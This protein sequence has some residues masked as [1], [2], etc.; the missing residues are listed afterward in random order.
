MG[1]AHI[2]HV[3]DDRDGGDWL[4]MS[5]EDAAGDVGGIDYVVN[6][7]DLTHQSLDEQ[8]RTYADIRERS[9]IGRW[10]EMSGNHD[11]K[12]VF[13][14]AYADI[15]GCPRYWTLVDGNMVFL[16]LPAE[17]GNAAGLF[18]P[19]VESWLRGRIAAHQDKNII[20]CAHQF[21][22]DTVDRSTRPAR[23]LYP[24][25]T[26]KR[27]RDDVRID[28]WLG[29]HI[30]SGPRQ[31]TATVTK[32]ATT[33]MNVASVSH[34]YDTEVCNSVFLDVED[35]SQQVTARCRDHDHRNFMDDHEVKVGLTYPARLGG[36]G[37]VFE[38]FELDVA[39]FYRNIHDEQVDDF[40]GYRDA[41]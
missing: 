23:C 32:G 4:R 27:F 13:R 22:Y 39:E 35:G 37:P 28:F 7:G 19:E 5:V 3:S 24:H 17:R 2:G 9:G 11:M 14:G 36:D 20:I 30:H 25:E 21:P 26:V 29:G 10:F 6:V 38:P 18:V 33:F 1:D 12:S 15:A 34:T 8:L 31:K 41:G 16:S 40:E